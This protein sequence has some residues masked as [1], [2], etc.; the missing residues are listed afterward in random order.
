MRP[1]DL[2]WLAGLLE[3]EGCFFLQRSSK[4]RDRVC[5]AV[6]STDEDVVARAAALMG[7]E[8]FHS[9]LR[10]ERTKRIFR[11]RLGEP[12]SISLMRELRPYMGAR[13]RQKIDE[14]LEA[15]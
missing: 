13:R 10:P 3:G 11:A 8:S 9:V 6:E 14:L 12:K 15:V 4:D 2:A 5:I 7:I 1:E